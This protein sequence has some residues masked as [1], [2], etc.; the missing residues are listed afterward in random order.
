LWKENVAVDKN[1][2]VV[3]KIY[4]AHMSKKESEANDLDSQSVTKV[5]ASE[6]ESLLFISLFTIGLSS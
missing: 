6:R 2:S 1:C 4:S 3:K 5:V